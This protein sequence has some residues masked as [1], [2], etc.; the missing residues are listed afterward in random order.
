MSWLE[1]L[2]TAADAV[3]SHRLRSMLTMLG[4]VI[5]ISSVVLTVGLGLG[6]QQQVRKQIDALGSNLLIVSPG[7]STNGSGVRGGFG[8]ASTLTLADAEAIADPAVAPDV[9]RVAPASTTTTSLTAGTTNWTSKVVGSTPSW[10]DVRSRTLGSGRFFTA[11]EANA[12]ANVV[13]LGSDTASELF[14]IGNPVGQTVTVN[15]TAL[16][17]IG[18]LDPSGATSS[19]SSE[20]DLAVVPLSTAQRLSGSTSTS[21]SAVYVEA[22]SADL[23]AA[24]YQEVDAALLTTHDVTTSEADFSIATQDALLETANSTNRT[25][26]ILLAG[27][28]A[29]SLLVGGI[30]VMNI[31]L[32]SVTERV[33]E[34]GLR[35]ALGATP[36]AIRRQFLLEASL[37]GVAGGVV[38]ALIGVVGAL[39]LPSLIDQPVALSSPAIA[40]ALLVALGL[41]VGFGVYPA[42]RA[43]RLTP[44]DALRSE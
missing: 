5:G 24:A 37:L 31:M 34:I 43:A 7:S 26:T 40:L 36:P 3:R 10:K 6:A 30:G 44:I 20:D 29:I 32:V 8:S 9:A 41:G 17:V 33:R 22:R 39:V 1:T 16:T 13:V 42:S 12:G 15:G 18:V 21:V 14:S 35:K 25:M 19:D 27:I 38:G 4:I 2:R 11:A 23:L 28:A